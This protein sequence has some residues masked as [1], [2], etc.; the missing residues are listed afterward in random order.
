MSIT[1]TN[2]GGEDLIGG[3]IKSAFK[4]MAAATYYRGQRLG[5]ITAT[6]KY[7]PFDS[8]AVDGSQVARAICLKD[9]VIAVEASRNVLVT[10]SE[11]RKG[12]IVDSSGDPLTVTQLI[13]EELQDVGIRVKEN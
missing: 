3:D 2:L 11:I 1:N 5:R 9:E 12:G 8:G 6:S 4:V 7:K 13:V 10:G